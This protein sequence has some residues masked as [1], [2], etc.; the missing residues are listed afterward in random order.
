M[1]EEGDSNILYA[2]PLDLQFFPHFVPKNCFLDTGHAG[3]QSKSGES[4]ALELGVS[5]VDFR[6]TRM[7]YCPVEIVEI[8][9]RGIIRML[10]PVLSLA[11]SDAIA[12]RKSMH[13]FAKT[14]I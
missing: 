12:E 8:L 9:S 14:S 13:A 5:V 10:K 6:E 3:N 11:V 1:A 7:D 4:N 2:T